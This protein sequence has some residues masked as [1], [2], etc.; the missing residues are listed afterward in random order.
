MSGITKCFYE[1]LT[2]GFSEEEM[3]KIEEEEMNSLFSTLESHANAHQI[4]YK[5]KKQE[6]NKKIYQKKKKRT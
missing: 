1:F 3:K 2:L 4:K 6:R 5:G